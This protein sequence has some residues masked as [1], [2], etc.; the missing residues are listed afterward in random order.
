MVAAGMT[1]RRGH[2]RG[3]FSEFRAF[4]QRQEQLQQLTKPKE[5]PK[6]GDTRPKRGPNKERQ[7]ERA[8]KN[9]EKAEAAMAELDALI[10]ENASD[11]QKLMELTEQK[12]RAEAELEELY[13]L[14][15]ELAE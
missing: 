11:Y 8:E 4:K 13:A 1:N 15:E 5:P 14:W 9:I 7:R 12:S 2:F 10:A 3:S 6:K